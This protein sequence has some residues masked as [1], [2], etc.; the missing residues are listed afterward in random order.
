VGFPRQLPLLS[1]SQPV[2]RVFLWK[3]GG[4]PEWTI[5]EILYPEVANRSIGQPSTSSIYQSRS[6][7]V[8]NCCIFWQADP[9]RSP[10]Q[11][12]T[13]S[14]LELFQDKILS[15]CS[16]RSYSTAITNV[17][18]SHGTDNIGFYPSLTALIKTFSLGTLIFGVDNPYIFRINKYN[19]N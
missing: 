2:R 4:Y 3:L 14:L 11:L 15:P 5:Y 19:E 9:P 1:L 8:C 10:L 7:I 17:L 12:V 6:S 16:N 13:D 18:P